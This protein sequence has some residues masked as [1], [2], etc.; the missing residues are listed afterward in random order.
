MAMLVLV[1]F[2]GCSDP[3]SPA[4]DCAPTDG[5][6]EWGGT[7]TGAG[8]GGIRGIVI[9]KTIVPIAGV[10]VTLVGTSTTTFTDAEGRFTFA[11][12]DPGN[13]FLDFTKA[14]FAPIQ[15]SAEVLADVDPQILKLQMNRLPGAEPMVIPMQWNGFMACSWYIATAFFTGCGLGQQ[16]DDD[17]RS[18]DMID[19]VPTFIQTELQWSHTQPA[20]RKLCMRQYASSGIGGDMLGDV[21]G[22]SPLAMQLEYAKIE[23]TGIGNTRGL[24]RVVWV[25]SWTDEAP[26]AGIAIDQDFVVYTHLFHNF[27]PVEGWMFVN[28]GAPPEPPT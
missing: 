28:D 26:T 4:A 2:A 18:F 5:C 3:S 13:Y 25:A 24:E 10:N 14:G 7:S 6:G 9:D 12:I 21:C 19:R 17:S 22:E 1:S 8:R 15:T 23:E 16:L 27:L 11:S 20:G